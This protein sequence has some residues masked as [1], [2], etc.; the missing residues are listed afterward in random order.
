MLNWVHTPA[1]MRKTFSRLVWE[2]PATEKDIYLTFDDG[3][4]PEITAQVLA[5]LLTY[6]ARATFFCLGAKVEQYPQLYEQ[7]KAAGHTIGNHGYHHLSGFSTS[8]KPYIENVKRGE[9]VSGSKLFRPPYGRIT[10]WQIKKLRGSYKIIMWSIMS[11]DFDQHT[12]P[13]QCYNNVIKHI[14]P[15]S[16]IV[17]H[18]IEK[19]KTN[20]LQALPQL[21]EWM[22]AHGYKA[23]ALDYHLLSDIPSV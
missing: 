20:V 17:F 18:D 12:T 14:K 2:I 9:E 13:E 7:I 22:N 1:W 6:N 3:P 21:L 4:T 23:K 8:L 5:L 16:I 11:M 15:G 19:A 10:P